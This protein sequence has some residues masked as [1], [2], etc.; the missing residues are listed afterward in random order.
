MI[1]QHHFLLF[2][3]IDLSGWYLSISPTHLC[4]SKAKTK[5]HFLW[6]RLDGIIDFGT[7]VHRTENTIP[8]PLLESIYCKSGLLVSAD[9]DLIPIRHL[10]S[11]G[12]HLLFSRLA[13]SSPMYLILLDSIVQSDRRFDP[14]EL[15]PLAF[16][17][18]KRHSNTLY[19]AEI[20]RA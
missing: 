10:F 7:C 11:G 3:L 9:R 4:C 17:A 5:S 19:L 1:L 20:S 14:A 8:F 16:P 13:G 18:D 15:N 2:T 6:A 12:F